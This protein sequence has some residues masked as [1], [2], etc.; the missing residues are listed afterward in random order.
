MYIEM[1]LRSRRYILDLDCVKLSLGIFFFLSCLIESF[2]Y[3]LSVSTFIFVKITHQK[4]AN[5]P[6]GL[7]FPVALTPAWFLGG[8]YMIKHGNNHNPWETIKPVETI[9]SLGK[10]SKIVRKPFESIVSFCVFFYLIF[11]CNT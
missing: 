9:N 11:M 5:L 8:Q 3:Q 7:I 1:A 2:C 6:F 10:L 4:A